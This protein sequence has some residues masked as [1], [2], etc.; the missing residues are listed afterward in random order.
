MNLL[1][2]IENIELFTFIESNDKALECIKTKL[3]D[4][5]YFHNKYL[6][7]HDL[8]ALIDY[9]WQ[10]TNFVNIVSETEDEKILFNASVEMIKEY[11]KSNLL[12]NTIVMDNIKFIEDEEDIEKIVEKPKKTRKKS[13]KK[14]SIDIIE[15][16][17]GETNGNKA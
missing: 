6:L 15:N 13:S 14:R 2:A 5:F 1:Q 16:I 12:K 4:G 11:K 8:D 3:L 10:M 17:G 7:E 9:T